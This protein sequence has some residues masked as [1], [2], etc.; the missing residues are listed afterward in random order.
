MS[1]LRPLLRRCVVF[2]QKEETE[3]SGAPDQDRKE[4]QVSVECTTGIAALST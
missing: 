3:A 1:R 2:E 4:A